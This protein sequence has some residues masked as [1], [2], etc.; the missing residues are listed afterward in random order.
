MNE[1]TPPPNKI[2]NWRYTVIYAVIGLVLAVYVV[3]LF[4]YQI[5][6][7]ETYLAQADENRTREISI[8]TERGIIYDRNGYILA[9]NVAS[10][11]LTITPALLPSE[12]GAM[13]EVFRQLSQ[14]I[15][16]PVNNG[17]INDE[18]VRLF[19]PC[20]TEMGITQIVY[21]ART[22]APYSPVRV[23][24]NIDETTAMIIRERTIDLPGVSIEIVPI[25][26]YPTGSLTAD[27]V[28]FLGPIPAV[29]SEEYEAQGLVADRDKVG[30]AGVEAQLQDILSGTNGLRVVEVDA[31]GAEVRELEPPIEAIP[32]LNVELTIDTRLQAAAQAALLGEINF[33]NTWFNE[34]R[35]NNA[36]V[37]A[38]N[39][40]TGELL[41]MVSYPTFENNRM[42][43]EIPAYYYEQLAADPTLPLFNHAISAELPPGS[44]FKMAAAIGILNEGV[45]TATQE[46][47]DPGQITLISR[48]SENEEGTPQNYVCWLETGHGYLD[49]LG[50]VANSCDVYFYKVGGG[51]GEEVPQGLGIWRLGEYA[52]ALGYARLTG[53]ELPGEADGLMPDPTWKRINLGQNWSTGDTYIATIGQSW[54]LATPLQVLISFAVLANDGVYMQPTIVHR[55]LDNNGNVVQDFEPQVVWDITQDPLIHVY[56]LETWEL[57][58]EMRTVEPWVVQLAQDAMREVVSS[59]TAVDEFTDMEVPSAGKTGTAEY[60][61]DVAQANGRCIPGSWPTHSWYVGYAPY[62]NPEIAVV[63]FVYNGGEGASVAAPIVRQVMEAYFALQAIDAGTSTGE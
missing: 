14:L 39:P 20:Q 19:T 58:G 48:Y 44:V 25:R 55:I 17:E 38:I 43:R 37:I 61:D 46:I 21:I 8:Q 3:K 1:Q 59:G 13:E 18:T 52:R 33:W 24:C 45:V 27:V 30:Y 49:F 60:C 35:I 5:I 57:T 2:E 42:A 56:D 32:G 15:N 10:Y 53:I 26:E 63:A 29:L 4:S 50:G 34:T 6:D 54:V 9:S 36:V 23:V 41:A 31:A 40:Q 62:D 51:F 11:N 28:G 12:E 22:N 47:F 7:N 16:V